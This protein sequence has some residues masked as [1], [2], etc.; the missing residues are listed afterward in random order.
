MKDAVSDLFFSTK[1]ALAAVSIV[2]G[3][4]VY[5]FNYFQTKSDADVIEKRQNIR[6]ESVEHKM[7]GMNEKI[8]RVSED[9]QYIRGRLEPRAGKK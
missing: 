9:T 3:I 2:V 6:I 7:D 1:D 5:S 8:G 4:V